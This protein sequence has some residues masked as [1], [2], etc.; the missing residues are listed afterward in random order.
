MI[1]PFRILLTNI[2]YHIDNNMN[3]DEHYCESWLVKDYTT[4]RHT[5]YHCSVCDRIIKIRNSEIKKQVNE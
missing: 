5:F 3:K 2:G 1:L 4:A